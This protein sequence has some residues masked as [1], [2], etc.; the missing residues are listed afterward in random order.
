[1]GFLTKTSKRR[2][3][4]RWCASLAFIY[5]LL[6]VFKAPYTVVCS[7]NTRQR[8]I[9]ESPIGSFTFRFSISVHTSPI[10]WHNTYPLF[11]RYVEQML[12]KAISSAK[13]KLDKHISVVVDAVSSLPLLPPPS[14]FSW[15]PTQHVFSLNPHSTT[16]HRLTSIIQVDTHTYTTLSLYP[17]P[18]PPPPTLTFVSR[19]FSLTP[20][21]CEYLTLSLCTSLSANTQ[22]RRAPGQTGSCR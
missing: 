11:A 13:N 8:I 7:S 22:D 10:V 17:L 4:R 18:P 3:K 9:K 2:K 6:C 19:T 12:Q 14:L 5:Y 20:S 16:S 15:T 21:L 1:M